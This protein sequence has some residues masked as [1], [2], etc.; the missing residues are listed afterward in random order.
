[1]YYLFITNS[2]YILDQVEY[3]KKISFQSNKVLF[4]PAN[5]TQKETKLVLF[6]T[7]STILP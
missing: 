2:K 4:P 7:L 1:M 3:A 5:R 6:R